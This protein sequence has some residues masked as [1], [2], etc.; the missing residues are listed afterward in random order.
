V[1]VPAV[2]T[3]VIAHASD[4]AE[5]RRLAREL[6][7]RL[8][9]GAAEGEEIA[10]VL[11]EL[12]SNL[13][14]HAG[15][16]TLHLRPLK[17]GG[18]PGLEIESVDRGP[19]I[20]NV[21]EALRDGFSTAGGLGYGLGV[22]NRLTDRLDI[23][24]RPRQGT[25]VLCRRYARP[26][27]KGVDRCPLAFGAATRA[28]PLMGVNGD[29]FVIK[30][31][32]ESALAGVID[33]LGHGQFAHR[34]AEAARQYVENHYDRPLADILRGANRACRATRGVVMALARFDWAVGKLTFASIGNVE[35]RVTGSREPMNL[36]VRRGVVGGSAPPPAVT[37]HPWR[38]GYLMVLHS[39][40]LT[41]R[42]RWEDYPGLALQP[43]PAVAQGLLWALAKE[44]D[45][46]TV[47]VVRDLVP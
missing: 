15:G 4:V 23:R 44:G 8:G 25:Q 29:A 10:L 46:A 5:A 24:S 47:V 17:E 38:A 28:H 39:D 33:G 37:E 20:A 14:R 1:D 9:F 34:A 3:L 18:R 16:G 11:S 22:V 41:T 42:W 31:W 45:D 19:G 43:A 21:E 27:E 36:L 6:A 7:L 13:V 26:D 40:G 12:A 35:A 2:Q 32:G 30:R